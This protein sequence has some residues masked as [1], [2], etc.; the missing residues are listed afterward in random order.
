METEIETV[1]TW[2]FARKM[3]R[4]LRDLRYLIPSELGYYG[5]QTSCRVFGIKKYPSASIPVDDI[6]AASPE[7]TTQHL[8]C[9]GTFT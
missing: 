1:I 6:D 7:P 5:I 8:V 3:P 4:N 9:R 2:G